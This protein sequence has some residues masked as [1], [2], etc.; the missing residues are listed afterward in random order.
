MCYFDIFIFCNVIANIVIF[1]TLQDYSTYYHLYSLYWALDHYG[2]F[3][4]HCKFVP[5]NTITFISS[6]TLFPSTPPF[7]QFPHTT[8]LLH[9]F[10]GLT[11]RICVSDT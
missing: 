11:F 7:P 9:I 5:L 3:T 6:T 10:P 1:I 4:V 8:I 2:S